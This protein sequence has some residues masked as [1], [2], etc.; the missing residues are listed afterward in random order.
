MNLCSR[1]A[2]GIKF[3][4]ILQKIDT[5]VQMAASFELK[6]YLSLTYDLLNA[7]DEKNDLKIFEIKKKRELYSIFKSAPVYRPSYV[8][9]T[10]LHSMQEAAISSL[11]NHER[12]F[13][14]KFSK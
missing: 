14:I 3:A 6:R 10:L 4:R 9:Q 13:T 1:R 2:F 11:I 12:T 7:L 5:I 8:N